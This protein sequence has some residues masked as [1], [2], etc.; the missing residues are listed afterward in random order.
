MNDEFCVLPRF[1][2]AD[3]HDYEGGNPLMALLL[4]LG[5]P[6]GICCCCRKK[7]FKKKATTATTQQVHLNLRNTLFVVL[8]LSCS[9]WSVH[10]LSLLIPQS[11]PEIVHTPPAGPAGPCPPYS[12]PGHPG[13]VRLL[14]WVK[15]D[16]HIWPPPLLYQDQSFL[17]RQ[18]LV[19]SKPNRWEKLGSGSIV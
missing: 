1:S 13:E 2:T 8:L 9:R 5:I 19:H 6:A 15:M 12:T 11:L 18:V 16:F 10:E 3:R 7:I 4:L 17:T 14:I